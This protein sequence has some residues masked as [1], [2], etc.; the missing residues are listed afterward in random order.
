MVRSHNSDRNSFRSLFAFP[1]NVLFVALAISL[2]LRVFAIQ[3]FTIPSGSMQPTLLVGDRILV[4][5]VTKYTSGI[6]RGDVVVFNGADVWTAPGARDE[7]VKRVVA[8]GGDHVQCCT[9]DGRI[10]VNGKPIT[11]PYLQQ[12]GMTRRFNV[13]VQPDRL[14]VLGDNRAASADSSAFRGVP[15]GGSVPV[16]HVVGKVVAVIWPLDRA[17]IL[18]T[19]TEGS[20]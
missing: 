1:W 4:E 17:G 6:H 12:Q 16:D 13:V 10:V 15:G 20:R 8:V 14:W 11:E 7:F 19:P 3:V 18:G 9:K 5:K 2:L